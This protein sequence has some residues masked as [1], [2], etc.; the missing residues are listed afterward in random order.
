VPSERVMSHKEANDPRT[1]RPAPGT[2]LRPPA[3]F[4]AGSIVPV[5]LAVLAAA[6]A[7]EALQDHSS[8]TSIVVASSILP[9]G[10]PV[11]SRDTRTVRVHSSDT[12]LAQ[13][14]LTPSQLDDGWVAAVAVHAGEPVTLSEVEKSSAVPALGEMSI[15][16]PL[17][18]AAGGRISPGD[19]VDVIASNGS[20]GAYYVAQGLR[21]LGV[22]PA[23]A[24][25]GVLAGGTGS[26]FIVVAVD[27]LTALRIAAALGAQGGGAAG[28]NVEIVRSSGESPTTQVRYGMSV[29]QPTQSSASSAPPLGRPQAGPGRRWS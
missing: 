27:K 10:A 20:E 28:D 3:R 4:T 25:T 6:F 9:V 12:A 5:L 2:R 1:E 7:Y 13:G 26:Y 17:Q 24:S 18:Q 11:D 8:M 19:L 29:P 16:V 23:S 15:A 21:V 14:L 22:A